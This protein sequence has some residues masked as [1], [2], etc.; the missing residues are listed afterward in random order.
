MG[1][2]TLQRSVQTK[3]CVLYG[4]TPVTWKQ[5]GLQTKAAGGSM[6]VPASETTSGTKLLW[7]KGWRWFCNPR[8]QISKSCAWICKLLLS[9]ENK[10]WSISTATASAK[11]S[12]IYSNRQ[13]ENNSEFLTPAGK[14]L[15]DDV[16]CIKCIFGQNLRL[17]LA[18]KYSSS[19][20]LSVE[21]FFSV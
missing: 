6:S 12:P 14:A 10:E 5:T 17:R 18:A 16:S 4:L 13:V 2:Q 1:H 21:P 8:S 7:R 20:L 19:I 3:T 11:S 9:L 15:I